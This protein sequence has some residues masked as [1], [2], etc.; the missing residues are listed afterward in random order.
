MQKIKIKDKGQG[1]IMQGFG[2]CGISCNAD[3][4]GKNC[5]PNV[6][7]RG[8][9]RIHFHGYHVGGK[10]AMDIIVLQ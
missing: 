2:A 8:H 1:K 6:R 10:A 4:I 7:I 9:E 3:D 5:L